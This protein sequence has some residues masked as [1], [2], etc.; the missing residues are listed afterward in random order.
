MKIGTRIMIGLALLGL[1]LTGQLLVDARAAWRMVEQAQA[2]QLRSGISADLMAG[3]ARLAVERG[4]VTGL[5]ANSG[6]ISDT[7]RSGV[8]ALRVAGNTAWDAAAAQLPAADGAVLADARAR[9]QVLRAEADRAVA[10][11]GP[12]PATWFAGATSAI[13]AVVALRRAIDARGN[14]ESGAAR[15]IAAGRTPSGSQ[16][17]ALGNLAG[18]VDGAWARIGARLQSAPP[19][20]QTAVAGAQTAW[21]EIFAP[22]RGAVLEAPNQGRPWPLPAS[23]WFAQLTGATLHFGETARAAR[24][25]SQA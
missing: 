9:L 11:Q 23:D 5:L 2:Q 1:A 22:T 20:L 3:S 13:D 10:G 25:L 16:L 15:L 8:A 17:M 24:A 18:H 6:A 4:M 21:G 19:A 14:T 7:Q 12:A